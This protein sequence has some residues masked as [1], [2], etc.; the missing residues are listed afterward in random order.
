VVPDN[1]GNDPT[2]AEYLRIPLALLFA[3]DPAG[4]ESASVRALPYPIEHMFQSSSNRVRAWL[5]RAE[6]LLS[7]VD[8]VLGDPPAAA[9]P[10]P[11]RRELRWNRPR[12][13]GAV[14]HPAA[15]CLCPVRASPAAARD[16]ATR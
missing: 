4:S 6:S 16:G 8:D 1:D 14:P 3:K 11:H 5:D 13:A 2:A 10:H 12:R 9:P 7:L 15:H